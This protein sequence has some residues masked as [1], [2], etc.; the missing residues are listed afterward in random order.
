MSKYIFEAFK[1][2]CEAMHALRQA[3]VSLHDPIYTGLE[4]SA[5]K[6]CETH[7]DQVKDLHV[8]IGELAV[9]NDFLARKLKPWTGK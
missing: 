8:K 5:L 2:I 9:A 1:G 4:S 7:E 3:D 6:I